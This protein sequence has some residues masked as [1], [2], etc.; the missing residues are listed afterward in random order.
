MHITKKRCN[1][2]GQNNLKGYLPT[3]SLMC[4]ANGILHLYDGFINKQI[5]NDI[6]VILGGRHE[7]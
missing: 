7:R 3:D 1:C 2:S 6:I 4:N 5:L